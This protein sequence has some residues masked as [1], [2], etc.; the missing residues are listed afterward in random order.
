MDDV[1]CGTYNELK[2]M[3][4]FSGKVEKFLQPWAANQKETKYTNNKLISNYRK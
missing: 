4:D 2:N 1:Q 3:A